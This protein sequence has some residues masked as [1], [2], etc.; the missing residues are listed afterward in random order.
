MA[1]ESTLSLTYQSLLTNTLFGYLDSGRFFD[2]I[3]DATPPLE[4]YMS[5][6]RLRLQRGGERLSVAIM[7]EL[8]DTAKSYSGY[9]VL[10]TT[11]QEGFTRAFYDWKQYA[12]AIAVNGNELTSN[13][14]EAELFDILA[15]KTSQAEI[16]LADK[17]STDLFSDGTG[18]SSKVLGGLQA[19]VD[20]SPT[21]S[22]YA[23]INRANN[24]AW[25]NQAATSV[26]AA[27]TQLLSNLRTQYNNC[28]QGKGG[29]GSK[30]DWL[31]TTQTVHEA[32]EALM[33]PFLQYQGSATNDNSVNAGLSN[34]RY[35]N[36][37]VA[38]DAD[39]PSGYLYILNGN[40]T[41]LAVHPDRN[42]SP[43]EGGFQKPVNQDA[44]ITQILFKGELVTNANK[45]LGVLTGI[46]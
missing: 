23:S 27:A 5:G 26:G 34:L 30:P 14:G 15:S 35:K 29:M 11:A 22:T 2:N 36:A 42:M 10:D 9:D 33:F 6:E 24:S 21:A 16:S 38:W 44:L 45:K 17:L 32:F 20:S 39:V 37:S 3:A 31:T 7:H 40:H 1:G 25:R 13:M 19:M 12:V 41:W 18:N 46:T 8:N 28:T 4:W 43:A